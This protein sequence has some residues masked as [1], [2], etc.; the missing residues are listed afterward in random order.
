MLTPFAFLLSSFSFF[1][2]SFSSLWNISKNATRRTACLKQTASLFNSNRLFYSTLY[3]SKSNPEES[4]NDQ[5]EIIRKLFDNDNLW[6][7]QTKN[8]RFFNSK[9]VGL[10]ENPHFNSVYAWILQHNKP[11]KE[12]KSL[13]NVFVTH[14][15]M[16]L[17]KCEKWS[18]I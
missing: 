1:F 2:M 5:E 8:K 18:R 14:P 15:R 13:L 7:S 9:P 3:R 11:Y 6:N 4:N 17:T 16:D 10:F 12:R